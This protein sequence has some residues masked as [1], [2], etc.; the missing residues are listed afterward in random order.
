[1]YLPLTMSRPPQRCVLGAGGNGNGGELSE[2]TPAMA[3]KAPGRGE[4]GAGD[5]GSG[6]SGNGHGMVVVAEEG[7]GPQGQVVKM[8]MRAPKAGKYDLMLYC[9]SGAPARL[10]GFGALF[11]TTSMSWPAD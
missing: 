9:I 5:N 2:A 1:M 11:R 6:H 8:Q 10:R 4:V 7:A 3:D